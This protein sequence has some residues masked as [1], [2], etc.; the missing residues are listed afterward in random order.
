MKKL[1]QLYTQVYFIIYLITIIDNF[2]QN[3]K[4]MFYCKIH[5]FTKVSKLVFV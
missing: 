4:Y 5:E 2:R 1:K 3:N